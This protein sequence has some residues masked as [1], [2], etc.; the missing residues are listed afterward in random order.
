M[1]VYIYIYAYPLAYLH[2]WAWDPVSIFVFVSQIRKIEVLLNSMS[3]SSSRCLCIAI[4]H[5]TLQNG[6][7]TAREMMYHVFF[8]LT[9]CCFFACISTICRGE[10]GWCLDVTSTLGAWRHAGVRFLLP[11]DGSAGFIVLFF[12]TLHLLEINLFSS[13]RWSQTPPAGL[14]PAIFGLEVRRLVH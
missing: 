14:E 10:S 5:F 1:C 11:G 8:K 13:W 12:S 3:I 9:T 4:S 2:A 7:S 6:M